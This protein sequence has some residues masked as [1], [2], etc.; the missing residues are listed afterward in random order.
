MDAVEFFTAACAICNRHISCDGCP[1][2]RDGHCVFEIV[3]PLTQERASDAVSVAKQYGSRQGETRATKIAQLTQALKDAETERTI[4]EQRIA[5]A[6]RNIKIA[7]RYL[8]ACKL[9]SPQ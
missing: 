6:D 3:S 5:A 7:K 4:L 9:E 8:E 1:A 2:K